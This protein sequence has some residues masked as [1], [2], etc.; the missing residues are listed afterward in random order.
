MTR[1]YPARLIGITFWL[2]PVLMFSSDLIRLILGEQ[3][4]WLSTHFFWLSF[5]AFLGVIFGMVQLSDYSP[6]SVTSALIAG[7]GAL[8]GITIIGMSRFAWGVEMEGVSHAVIVSADSNPWVFFTS[9][10]TGITFPIGLIMLVVGLK[11]NKVV[12]GYLLAG[13]ILSILLF[14]LGRI[15]KELLVNVVGDGLMIIFFGMVGKAYKKK[16]NS[17]KNNETA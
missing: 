11:R 1:N 3:S 4:F 2:A 17:K 7:F 8:T 5:Y 12:N 15:P 14:P 13:L 10:F 6:Y 9:R 16:L